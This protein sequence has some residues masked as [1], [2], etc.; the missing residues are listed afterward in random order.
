MPVTVRVQA[1]EPR[2][3]F[4]LPS[5]AGPQGPRKQMKS[6]G[7]PLTMAVSIFPA[8][9]K[10]KKELSLAV[11]MADARGR[12]WQFN[13]PVHVTYTERKGET[14]ETFPIQV[15]FSQDKTGFYKEEARRKV[16]QQAIADWAF[17]LAPRPLDEVAAGAE[18][19]PIFQ[20]SGF[21]KS[22]TVVNGKAYRGLLLYTYGIDGPEIRSG[23][24]PARSGFQMSDGQRLPLRR[25]GGVEIEIKGNYNKLGWNVNIPDDQWFKATNLGDVQNDLY[26]IAHHESGHA[27][28]FN[29]NNPKWVR[30][31]VLKNDAVRAYLGSDPHTDTHDHLDAI[32]DP[33]SLRGAFGNEYHGKTPYGRW[34]ITKLD[35]L[36]AQ[37]VG[38]PLRDVDAIA[39]LTLETAAL[40]NATLHRPYHE[41]LRAH[42]GIPFYDWTVVEGKL[43]AGLTLNRFTEAITGTP[44]GAED[45]TFTVQVRDYTKN[46]QG[47][48]QH[49]HLKV[50]S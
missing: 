12:R 35:L 22:D 9:V 43:P 31:G 40:A 6:N 15:D 25:S 47:I 42:G 1:K 4:D 5:E 48:R 34:L 44:T 3:Y 7:P 19:T 17:Y 39:P 24:E 8:R 30:N 41:T 20:P 11:E 46:G 50:G 45:A 2:L 38:Y 16:F 33:A 27:L 13:V 32:I 26:S 29:P 14:P 28:F 23:G 37:A 49:L 36:C 10:V 18:K 21:T